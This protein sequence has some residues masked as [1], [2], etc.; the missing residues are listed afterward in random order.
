MT[1]R[2][3]SGPAEAG[4]RVPE[5]QA[6][7][8]CPAGTDGLLVNRYEFKYLIPPRLVQPTRDFIRPFVLPDRFADSR[9]GPSYSICSLYFDT[10]DLELCRKTLRGEKNRYKLRI[11][12][13]SE[14]P[15]QPVFLEVKRRIDAMVMKRRCRVSRTQALAILGRNSCP[16][17]DLTSELRAGLDEFLTLA[18]AGARPVLRVKYQR[19]AYEARGAEPVRITL[20][21]DLWHAVSPVL[22]LSHNSSGWCRTPVGGVV[23]EIKLT[24]RFPSWVAALVRA[25]D[26]GRLSVPKYCLSMV[27]AVREG[28]YRA[29]Q[30]GDL[31]SI[32][33]GTA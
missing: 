6:L 27:C 14:E 30:H 12:S 4:P 9:S 32:L 25:L 7:F 2:H 17:L 22:D 24:E 8:R 18:A 23:L 20:D 1:I 31:E 10:A 29:P 33:A 16:V 3:E 28:R 11:R 21:T 26:L 19:E 13:Y 15:D 5:I